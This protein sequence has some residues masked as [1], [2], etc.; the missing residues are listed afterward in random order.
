MQRLLFLLVM[1]FLLLIYVSFLFPLPARAF[2]G[3]K[4]FLLLWLGRRFSRSFLPKAA[5]VKEMGFHAEVQS[6]CSSD[7]AGPPGL[8]VLL[9]HLDE[10]NSVF[11]LVVYYYT[12]LA[13]SSEAK[14]FLALHLPV[15]VHVCPPF[16]VS[17]CRHEIAAVKLPTYEHGHGC[18]GRL[19]KTI[20]R[21]AK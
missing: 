9:D 7:C 20:T 5:F 14:G 21:Y 18:T 17:L 16:V 2:Q 1:S 13:F 15:N 4:E 11:F 19:L 8:H 12:W 3:P 10:I 6:D